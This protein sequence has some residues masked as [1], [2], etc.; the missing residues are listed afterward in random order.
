MKAKRLVDFYIYISAPLIALCAYNTLYVYNAMK[1]TEATILKG[2]SWFEPF[3]VI[4]RNM[5]IK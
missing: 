4:L 5:V 2:N 3:F 1:V